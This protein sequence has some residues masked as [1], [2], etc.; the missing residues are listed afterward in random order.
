MRERVNP[1]P[2]QRYKTVAA[3]SY[4]RGIN[5]LNL[6][7]SPKISNRITFHRMTTVFA[8]PGLITTIN[9]PGTAS[10]PGFSDPL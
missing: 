8:P 2:A 5:L 7:T 9:S 6:S 4:N 10:P 1:W 3:A